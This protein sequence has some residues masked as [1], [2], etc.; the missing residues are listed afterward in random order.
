M[1][2][3]I[4]LLTCLLYLGIPFSFA[5]EKHAHDER[6]EEHSEEEGHGDHEDEEDGEGHAGHDQGKEGEHEEESSAVGPGKGITEKGKA[7]IKL[8]A[9]AWKV[10]EIQTGP[11]S[12]K[13]MEISRKSLVEIKSEKA[14]YRVRGEWIKK[15]SVKVLKKNGDKILIEISNHQPG[16]LLVTSGVGFVRTAELVAEEGAASG[17]SH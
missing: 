3:I 14:I 7:G 11:I 12:G 15:I 10:M 9:K 8:S 13:I 17:H 2:K 16:D 1:K 6:T 5:S 4:V